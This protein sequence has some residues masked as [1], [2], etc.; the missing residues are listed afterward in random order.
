M[1]FLLGTQQFSSQWS[2]STQESS[3]D[4]IE[5]QITPRERLNSAMKIL[6]K[7][8]EPL[9]HQLCH[10]WSGIRKSSKSYYKKKA[11]EMIFLVFSIIAPG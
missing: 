3:Q 9:K 8:F 2:N 7:D 4:W 11:R 1:C 10:P 6:S 5:S